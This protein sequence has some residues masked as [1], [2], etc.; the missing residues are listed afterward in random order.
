MRL[1]RFVSLAVCVASCSTLFADGPADNQ[2]ATVRQ[3]PPPGVMIDPTD[4]EALEGTLKTLSEKV[5]ELRASKSAIV[6]QY[7]PDVEIFARAVKLALEEDGFFDPS[8]AKRA[9]DVLA[10]GLS[11]AEALAQGKTPWTTATGTVVRGFRSKLDGSVQPYGI[12][13]RQDDL[14]PPPL[15][16]MRAD[17]WCRGRS[18]KGLELQFI[19]Q[20]MTSASPEPAPG[21]M[22][23]HP[24]G[25]YCNANKLAGEV[26][27]LEVLEHALS[28]YPIDPQRVAI[29]GFSMGGAAAWHLAVH[30]PDKWFAATPGA[31]FSETP[32]F[33][34][35]FQKE[36]LKPYPFEQTLWQMYDCPVWARNLRMLPTIAYSG[37]IDSQK[38]AA[39]I[40]AAACWGLPEGERFELTHII[41]PKTGHSITPAAK[42]EIE[43]RLARLDGLRSS[44]PPRSVSFTTTTLKYDSS[45]WIQVNALQE[46]WKP[47]SISTTWNPEFNNNGTSN[48][49]VQLEN[50]ND[51]SIVFATGDAPFMNTSQSA[52]VTIASPITEPQEERTP[53]R[54]RKVIDQSLSADERALLAQEQAKQL[55][56]EGARAHQKLMWQSQLKAGQPIYYVRFQSGYIPL[57]S[58]KSWGARFRRNAEGNWQLVSPIEPPSKDLVKKHN[59]QG[60]IDDAFMGPFLFVKPTAAGRHPEVDQWVDA[61]FNRAVR[62]WHRQMR[63]DARVKTSEELKPEDIENYHLILWG[64]PQSN[65][66]IAKVA[67]KLPIQWGAEQISVGEQKFDAKSH[68]PVLIYP[69]PLNPEKY[70]VLNSSFTYREYDY[71]NNA[72]QVPKLPDWAIIDL[73]TPPD[74][75]WPGKIA[76][77]DFFG[78]KW[79]LKPAR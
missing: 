68:A 51:F 67:D 33:L 30:Y 54:N 52:K 14:Y 25:R 31:G 17:I 24:F 53:E 41:A 75:R 55:L 73:T 27:T 37:E 26:D 70:V 65:P 34:K 46:H 6:Q 43:K 44:T 11:R 77:A 48:I 4:R 50:I 28:E 15:S 19:A 20:R 36:E 74:A 3:V 58:D 71:L 69:N 12:V 38:Q 23:I 2:W 57:R 16:G 32:D 5:A 62:E 9:K 45:H 47:S 79:E 76:A 18:E 10:E 40:M 59:L 21:V 66:T 7:L 22:M 60:P 49:S 56:E 1:F 13:Y 78:E 8:D 35:V 39:D 29:R 64:D 63:G 61:E 72:R 42:A